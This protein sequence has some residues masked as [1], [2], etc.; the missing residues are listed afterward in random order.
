MDFLIFVSDLFRIWDDTWDGDR[1]HSKDEFDQL[2]S[3]LS[4]DIF[5]NKFFCENQQALTSQIFIA[6]NAW[7]DSNEW[8]ESGNK[9]QKMCAWFIRDYCNEICF[10]VAWITGGKDFVR[11][12][13]IKTRASYLEKL[14]S[15][16][17]DGFE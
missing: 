12:I 6:W 9:V 4:F 16:G 1:D 13:S 14:V 10:L 3:L 7:K 8:R 15:G 5:K 11:E 2:F 17:V